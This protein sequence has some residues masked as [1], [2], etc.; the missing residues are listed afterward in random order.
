M[1]SRLLNFTWPSVSLKEHKSASYT[2]SGGSRPNR[3]VDQGS[4]IESLMVSVRV[5]VEPIPYYRPGEV[6]KAQAYVQANSPKSGFNLTAKL[7][8][9][10]HTS[11]RETR[12]CGGNA[13]LTRDQNVYTDTLDITRNASV[14]PGTWCYA[15]EFKMPNTEALPSSLEMIHIPGGW[16]SDSSSS[17]IRYK[18]EV[19][20]E[21]DSGLFDH[22]RDSAPFTYSNEY[23]KNEPQSFKYN[24]EVISMEVGSPSS[25]AP[26]NSN[27]MYSLYVDNTQSAA[28]IIGFNVELVRVLTARAM[29]TEVQDHKKICELP[30]QWSVPAGQIAAFE[31]IFYI[32]FVCNPTAYS[33]AIDCEYM[34]VMTPMFQAKYEMPQA[35]LP[36]KVIRPPPILVPAPRLAPSPEVS[37]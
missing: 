29:A 16:L 20:Y 13:V 6:I 18:I 35:K 22:T 17:E 1:N 31:D 34:L 8:G 26:M 30:R 5:Q 12:L 3:L 32:P 11:I 36:I 9:K 23:S 24:G 19:T 21:G 14:P 7:V 15:F 28:D 4:F 37:E 10:C 2:K 27:F 25:V 33:S